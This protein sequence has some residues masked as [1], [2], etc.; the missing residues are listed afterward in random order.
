MLK[1]GAC[2]HMNIV[3]PDI[4]LMQRCLLRWVCQKEIQCEE[5]STK[6]W[7][8]FGSVLAFLSIAKLQSRELLY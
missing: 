8:K 6:S 3:G 5:S 2:V 4:V 1:L 7:L